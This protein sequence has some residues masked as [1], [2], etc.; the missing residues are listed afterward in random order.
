MA[1]AG[2]GQVQKAGQQ[3]GQIVAH[4]SNT[5]KGKEG[6]M[7]A[8]KLG[9]SSQGL[10]LVCPESLLLC[11]RTSA[12]GCVCLAG[13]AGGPGKHAQ[14][15]GPESGCWAQDEAF[16]GMPGLPSRANCQLHSGTSC[17]L[18]FASLRKCPALCCTCGNCFQGT[19]KVAED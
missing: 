1:S 15:E 5:W 17:T 14:A 2:E 13:P 8:S 18:Q 19:L 4:V 16:M 12:Q 9:V 7:D 11:P 3:S 10:G 6:H